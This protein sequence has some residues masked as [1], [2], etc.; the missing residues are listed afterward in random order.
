MLGLII[1]LSV[2]NSL[3][4][5]DEIN[6][7]AQKTVTIVEFVTRS[8]LFLGKICLVSQEGRSDSQI[9]TYLLWLL[10]AY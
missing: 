1:K 6:V 8:R 9:L 5:R 10:I 2:E 4:G 7:V 3:E